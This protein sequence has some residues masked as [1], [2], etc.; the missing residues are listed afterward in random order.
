MTDFLTAPP[1][2][3]DVKPPKLRRRRAWV[4]IYQRG[5][6][7]LYLRTLILR[8]TADDAT[9][10]LSEALVYNSR[11]LAAET[12]RHHLWGG[13]WRVAPVFV[14]PSEDR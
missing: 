9:P 5:D 8:G 3:A 7:L 2:V 13:D 4:L 1:P 11:R 14:T 12:L 6:A 10:L